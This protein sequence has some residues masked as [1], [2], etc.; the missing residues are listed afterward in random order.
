MFFLRTHGT[1]ALALLLFVGALC[2]PARVRAQDAD[3][4][5]WTQFNF[6]VRKNNFRFF[7]EIQPR[8]GTNYGRTSQFIFRTAAGYNVTKEFSIWLGYGWTPSFTPE[9][10]NEDRWFQQFLWEDSYHSFK[11]V[12]RFRIEERSISGAEGVPVRL[13]HLLKFTMPFP[14]HSLWSAIF[15]NELF[16][17]WNSV[18]NGPEA[19]FDQ[20]RIFLG[21][22]YKVSKDV[23][24]ELGYLADLIDSP[25]GRPNRRLDVLMLTMNFNFNP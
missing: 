4:Q 17:N 2:A 1:R 10:N 5:L 9:F 11:M 13:R 19:G 7:G 12:N 3:S 8:W 23:G 15:S 24:M 21:F 22:G 14:K 20:D 16:W 6:N 18:R 25:G